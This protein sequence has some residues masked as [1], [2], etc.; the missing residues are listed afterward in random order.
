MQLSY[1]GTM[2]LM[3]MNASSPPYV[4]MSCNVSKMS[5][6]RTFSS[7]ARNRCVADVDVSVLEQVQDGK[8]LPVVRHQGLAHQLRAHDHLLQQLAHDAHD[9]EVARVERRLDRDDQLRDDGQDLGAAVLE[10][11]E[12]ALHREEA[13]RLLLL[14]QAVEED[15]QVVVVVSLST[16]TFHAMT[17]LLEL[18]TATGKSPRS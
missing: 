11:V 15:R 4:S 2:Y 12:D 17:F 14:A 5:S 3:L 6:P 18:I 7:S 16:S 9:G 13:V 10:H 8:D 1:V